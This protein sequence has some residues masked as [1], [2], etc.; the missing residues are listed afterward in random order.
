MS[1]KIYKYMSSIAKSV[2]INKLD[3]V[4]NKYNNKFHNTIRIK[5]LD[6]KSSTYIDFNKEIN[7]KNS[8]C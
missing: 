2:S 3:D 1:N 4:L 5:S 8:K 7:D 6:V